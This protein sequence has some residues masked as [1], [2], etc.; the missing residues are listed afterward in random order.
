M[1]RLDVRSFLEP[2]L[3]GRI[4]GGVG[5]H[6]RRCLEG[7]LTYGRQRLRVLELNDAELPD[8]GAGG[9]D[10]AVFGDPDLHGRDG[11]RDGQ[12][13]ALAC[14]RAA[15]GVNQLPLRQI[16]EMTRKTRKIGMGVMGFSDMLIKLG[17]PY[18]S[19]EAM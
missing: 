3:D 12:R 11:R 1:D 14:H 5:L 9:E 6:A 17:I 8:L 19:E 18:N 16:A 15:Q 4:G 10:A 7:V 2:L 13:T